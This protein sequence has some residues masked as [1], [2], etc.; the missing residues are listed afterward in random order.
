[1]YCLDDGGD[2]GSDIEDGLFRPVI[3]I[4]I[5]TVIRQSLSS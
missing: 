4:V 3:M 2:D 1:M 5:S